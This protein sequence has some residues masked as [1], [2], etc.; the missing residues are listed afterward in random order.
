MFTIKKE[1][2]LALG[3]TGKKNKNNDDD[4]DDERHVNFTKLF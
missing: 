3:V 1:G 4:D 2:N